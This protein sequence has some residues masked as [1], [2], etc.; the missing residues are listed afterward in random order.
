MLSRYRWYKIQL[1][2][3][4]I[5]L[6]QLIT[7]QPLTQDGSFGFS[8]LENSIS[9]VKYRFFWRTKVVI[10][11]FD[12]AGEPIYEQIES[13]NFTDF[14]IIPMDEVTLLRVENPTKSVR[15]LLNALEFII[16]FG[17]TCKPLTFERSRPTKI[18]ESV[19]SAKLISLK[20]LGAV[21]DEDLVARMEFVSKQG[22]ELGRIQ[23]LHGL[24]YKI[25]YAV[26]ELVSEGVRGQIAFASSGLVKISG[27]LS[28]KLLALVESDLYALS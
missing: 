11:R 3:T 1:P 7:Q 8:V 23:L 4:K 16:G 15:A 17:F 26:F 2:K 24:S 25:D 20:V 18:F 13:V 10:T 19:D 6:L 9:D 12:E 21:V 27:Q 14:A 5:D 28:P 22:M